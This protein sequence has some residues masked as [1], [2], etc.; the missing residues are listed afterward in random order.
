MAIVN[1]NGRSFDVDLIAFDKDGTLLDLHH[2]WGGLAHSWGTMLADAVAEPVAF[3]EALY[4]TLGY[5]PETK[6][7]VANCPLAIASMDKLFNTVAIVLYQHGVGWVEA[8]SLLRERL[9]P[10]FEQFPPAEL[11]Q[12]LGVV[13]PTIRALAASGIRIAVI[14]TDSRQPALKA[15]PVLEI[16]NEVEILV[17]GDDPIPGKPLPDGLLHIGR[18]TGVAPSRML[19]VGDSKSDLMCGRAAGAAGCIGVRGGA[20]KT[21]DLEKHGDA[22]VD[23]IAEIQLLV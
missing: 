3:Q 15:L 8:E 6:K 13:A 18:E 19:M 11:V 4:Q 1:V 20:G 17:C 21:A 23:S 16:A 9:M 2:M 7:V 22:V 12:P 14:T 10:A 5:D